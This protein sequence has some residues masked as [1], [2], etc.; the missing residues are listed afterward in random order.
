VKETQRID[1][2]GKIHISSR[3]QELLGKEVVITNSLDA[4]YICVYRKDYFESTVKPQF[5]KLNSVNPMVRKIQRRII[6]EAIE[7]TIDRQGK[8]S[9]KDFLDRIEAGPEDEIYIFSYDN[10]LE[11]CS[12]CFYDNDDPE[13]INIDG[14]SDT[15][16]LIGI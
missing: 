10:K 2:K 12:K 1:T 11:I 15:Y 5:A 16:S 3:Q 13:M 4:K 14:L 8:I 6:G 9:L 7:A